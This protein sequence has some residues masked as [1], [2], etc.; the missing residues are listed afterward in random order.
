LSLPQ[1]LNADNGPDIE[2]LQS[3]AIIINSG[4]NTVPVD[5]DR[6]LNHRRMRLGWT[7]TMNDND[8][9]LS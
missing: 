7:T 1:G 9:G 8:D 4:A 3:I 2:L 5:S 6:R